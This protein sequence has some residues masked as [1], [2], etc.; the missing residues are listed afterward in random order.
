MKKIIIYISIL[1]LIT[2]C[3][4]TDVLDNDPPNNLVAENVVQN[5]TDAK[6][7]L[8]GVYT[9]ITSR[10]NALYYMYTELIPS[11]MVGSMSQTGGGSINGQFSVNDVLYDNFYVRD[12][13]LVF[14][15]VIDASNNSIVLTSQL[16]EDQISASVKEEIIGEAHFLRAMATFDALRYFGQFFDSSSNLGVILRTEP[17][18]FVTRNKKR[19]TVEETYAQILSDIEV[20]LEKAPDYSVSYRGSKTAAKALKAKVLLYQGKYAEAA[21]VADEVITDG[22]VSL[23]PTFEAAFSNG[24][25]SSEMIL[26]TYRDENSD[27]EDNNRKR[28]YFGRVASGWFTDLIEGDPRQA[29]TYSGSSV[30]KTNNTEAFRPTYFMR[31]AEMYLIKAEGL[32]FSGAS[33]EDSSAPLNIIRNRA[34]IGDSPATT[35]EELKDDIFN[36]ITRELAFENGSEWFAAIRFN[37]IMTLKPTVTSSNQYILPIPEEEINGNGSITLADQ[38]PG[39]E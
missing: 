32:A 12:L 8:N 16:T 33:L 36:E 23:E 10:T 39:Y 13:W 11:A 15:K 22:F 5:E 21:A 14:Y 38:N 18:N 2:S 7:L 19:S 24:L 20:A 26:M 6:A 28:F 31:L 3:E 35:M 34:T 29:L 1:S 27:S 9:T 37:K 30:L 25:N 17:S 4:L